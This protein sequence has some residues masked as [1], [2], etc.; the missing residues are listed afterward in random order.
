MK[1]KL[2]KIILITLGVL[3]VLVIINFVPTWNL[4]TRGMSFYKGQWVNVYYEEEADAA[5]DVFELT[6]KNA[7]ALSEKLGFANKQVINIYIYDKQSTMHTKKYGFMALFL[8][9]DWYIGDNVGAHVILTSPAHPGKSHD[10]ENV[11]NAV[12]HEMVHAYVSVI[13]PD[14][15]LWLTEGMALYL[16]NGEPLDRRFFLFSNMPSYKEINTNNPIKFSNIGGYSLAHTYIE[17]LDV[18][19]GWDKVMEIVRTEN[20][21]EAIGKSKEETYAEWV[22]Y[23]AKWIAA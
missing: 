2:F 13:N 3:L 5:K 11:K 19:Y 8:N 9:L 14:I 17:Y 15:S 21:K 6:E 23:I 1:K 20:Y 4:K 18:T 10:Y 22:R 7:K 12:L 16:S